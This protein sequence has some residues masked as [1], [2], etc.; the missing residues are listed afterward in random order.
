MRRMHARAHDYHDTTSIIITCILQVVTVCCC[1]V[2]LLYHAF[3]E[4]KLIRYVF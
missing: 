4:N 2:A 1:M 3:S